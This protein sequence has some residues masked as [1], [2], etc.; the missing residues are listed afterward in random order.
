MWTLP[1]LSLLACWGQNTYIVE[2]TVVEVHPPHEVVLD[3]KDI[4]GF[5]GAMVMPFSVDD[6]A[7]LT[8]LEPGHTVLGRLEVADN[9]AAI[10]KIRITG[11]GAVPQMVDDG[12]LPI[13]PGQKLPPLQVEL[14]DGS[15]GLL[16]P[17][18]DRPT[19]LAFVYTRCP[20]PD[21]CP[22]TVAR[23]QALQ[24]QIGPEQRILAMTLDPEFDTADVLADY[25]EQSSADVKRWRF[26]R[27]SAKETAD[28]AIL[29]GMPVA[30]D[31][32]GTIVHALRFMVIDKDGRLI[33]RYDDN[34]WPLDRVVTQLKTGGPAAP[35]GTASTR[36]PD[37]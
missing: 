9:R 5:M 7:L 26:G 30:K 28:L 37:E 18:Q 33:E 21:Y 34:N 3:H 17:G 19:A 24:A 27:F 35:K 25:A 8:G 36:T 20:M 15:V 32:T 2:G 16:G 31:E 23:L 11:Q 1:I 4:P 10:T 13:R 29:A 14:E 12:P 22:A 6:P